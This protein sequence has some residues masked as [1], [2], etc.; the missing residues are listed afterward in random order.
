LI[1]PVTTIIPMGYWHI[2]PTPSSRLQ[3]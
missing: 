3:N 1:K 2:H